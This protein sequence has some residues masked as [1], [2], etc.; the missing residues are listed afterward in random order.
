MQSEL[1]RNHQLKIGLAIIPKFLKKRKLQK[2]KTTH[3]QMYNSSIVWEYFAKKR[4]VFSEI[5][6]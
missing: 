6:F 5:K 4:K 2:V 1:L 3:P